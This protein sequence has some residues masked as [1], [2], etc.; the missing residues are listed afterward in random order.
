MITRLVPLMLLLPVLA[1]ADAVGSIPA[2][3]GPTS[4]APIGVMGD[5][6]HR[7]G[8]WMVSYRLM[9]MEMDGLR[10]GDD[11]ISAAQVTGTMMAPGAYRVAPTRMTMSMQML[12]V[13]YAPSDSLTLMAMTSYKTHEMDHITRMGMRFTTKAEGLGDTRLAGLFKVYQSADHSH[14]VHVSAGLSVP[15]G[16][17]D[18]RDDTPAMADAKLPYGMQLGSGSYDLMPG[19]TYQGYA[20][21]YN[22]GAQL[23]AVL[24]LERNDNKYRFGNR[25]AASVW[26]ARKASDYLSYSLRLYGESQGKL[27]GDRDDLNPMMVTT[28]DPDNYGGEY[29]SLSYGLNLYL[30]GGALK[31]HRFALEYT[32]PLYQKMNGIQLEREPSLNAGWQLAF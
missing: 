24:P 22:W 13:M 23:A 17:I 21:H 9:D 15:T 12:G 30:P 1:L 2:S 6:T 19:V 16:S 32:I 5:H 3:I 31:G 18:E 11:Q 29:A 4:H 7:A 14:H 28:A 20:G 27:D 8:E 25:G 10:D 26:V